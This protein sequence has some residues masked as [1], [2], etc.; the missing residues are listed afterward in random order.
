MEVLTA[1]S[2]I[3]KFSKGEMCKDLEKLQN[4]YLKV[5]KIVEERVKQV[6]KMVSY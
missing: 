4:K 6:R 5:S 1:S 3:L 2:E